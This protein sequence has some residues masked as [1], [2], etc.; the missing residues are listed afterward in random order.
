MLSTVGHRDEKDNLVS[1]PAPN[2]RDKPPG[3]SP[4]SSVSPDNRRM[5][6]HKSP[7]WVDGGL[8]LYEVVPAFDAA[9]MHP[10][11]SSLPEFP[12]LQI[13]LK[14]ASLCAQ[15]AS[16]SSRSSSRGVSSAGKSSILVARHD[17]SRS[18]SNEILEISCGSPRSPARQPQR[19]PC[20]SKQERN[21]CDRK[22]T[23]DLDQVL[24]VFP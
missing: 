15:S 23:V 12:G 24:R 8:T 13:A 5:I 20:A 3:R 11:R 18:S 9:R 22:N 14:T 6:A 10:V 1:R 16:T 19:E 21:A 7:R 2:D 17:L 4:P